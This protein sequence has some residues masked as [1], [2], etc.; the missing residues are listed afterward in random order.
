[1]GIQKRDE[2][3]LGGEVEIQEDLGERKFRFELGQLLYVYTE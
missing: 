1:M 3:L 2:I